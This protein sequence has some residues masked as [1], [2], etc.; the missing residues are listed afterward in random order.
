MQIT[1]CRACLSKSLSWF[2]HNVSLSGVQ[3]GRLRSNE[4]TCQFVLGCD[5]CSET[6]AVVS[7]DKI[8][9][10]LNSRARQES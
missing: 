7:A 3:E 4:V 6:L 1:E 10:H 5:Y 2:T 9:D 8:A